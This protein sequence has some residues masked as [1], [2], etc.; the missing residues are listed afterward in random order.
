MAIG[1]CCVFLLLQALFFYSA[2]VQ[3]L[4]CLEKM[5]NFGRTIFPRQRHGRCCAANINTFFRPLTRLVGLK[6]CC[7]KDIVGETGLLVEPKT[8]PSLV[9]LAIYRP[10]DWLL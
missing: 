4:I 6:S 9:Q 10:V 7:T 3:I 2:G 8:R 1:I 5:Y